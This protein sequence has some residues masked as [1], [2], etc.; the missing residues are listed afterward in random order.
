MIITHNQAITDNELQ[1]LET[2]K[3]NETRRIQL[4]PFWGT[5]FQP[6]N[7]WERRAFKA[8]KRGSQR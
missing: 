1:H 3:P 6:A 2:I 4:D 8:L 7:R 5:Q